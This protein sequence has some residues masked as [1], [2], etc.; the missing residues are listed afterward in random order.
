LRSVGASQ[1]L[2]WLTP[3]PAS[4]CK[5]SIHICEVIINHFLKRNFLPLFLQLF[6][7]PLILVTI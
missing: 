5:G 4:F 7:Y 6:F 1:D 2:Y 3:K